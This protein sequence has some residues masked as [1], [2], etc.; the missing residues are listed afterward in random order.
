MPAPYQLVAQL[1]GQTMQTVR[2]V[3]DGAYIP[4]ATPPTATG[5]SICAWIAEGNEPDPAPEPTRA[6][7]DDLASTAGQ[8]TTT[9]TGNPQWR[10]AQLHR[11]GV[12]G[13]DRT[14][15]QPP[16]HRHVLRHIP[17]LGDADGVQPDDWDRW[18]AYQ[19]A[20]RGTW[21]VA[22]TDNSSDTPTGVTNDANHPPA[23][24][25]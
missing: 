4:P 12:P 17:G 7:E 22:V 21:F 1:P 6:K 9:P 10:A 15:D 3:A 18:L 2:R 16:A 24:V 8:M 19:G 11:L 13:A 25:K 20:D 23:G 5:R 14:A